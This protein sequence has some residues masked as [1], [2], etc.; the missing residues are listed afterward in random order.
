[1]DRDAFFALPPAVAV[2]VLFD[3]LDE[4]TA[5]AIANAEAPKL[6]L[7]PKFDRK[8]F[9][10]GG[11]M[12]ASECDMSGLRFWHGKAIEPPSDTKYAEANR[13]QA[14]ELARWI[15]WRE[16]YPDTTWSGERDGK[17]G[18]ARGPS[19]KPK[20]Y[21]R[22]PGNGQRRERQEETVDPENW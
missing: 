18:V 15:A 8:I 7:P 1:M 20:I 6:P 2:R 16:C 10:Q 17:Q 19:A 14:E 9:R 4:D 12:W 22:A 5:R 13:K 11:F 3:A 21:P